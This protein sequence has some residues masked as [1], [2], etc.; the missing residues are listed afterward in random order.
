MRLMP[1]LLQ[2]GTSSST[3]RWSEQWQNTWS[4]V[5][6]WWREVW[7]KSAFSTLCAK[8]TLLI[9]SNTSLLLTIGSLT[10]NWSKPQASFSITSLKRPSSVRKLCSWTK[11]IV[12]YILSHPFLNKLISYQ[13]D[14]CDEELVDIYIAFLKSLVLQLNS[15]TI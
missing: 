14:Y 7:P 8:E 2:R 10:F 15:D 13:Y 12:D 5:R 9:D 6:S 1:I 11:L 4:M 3:L